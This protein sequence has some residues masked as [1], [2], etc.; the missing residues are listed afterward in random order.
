M[1]GAITMLPPLSPTQ[2]VSPSDGSRS[3]NP[4]CRIQWHRHKAS[5]PEASRTSVS[6]TRGT[7]RSSS[8]LGSAVSSSTPRDFQPSSHIGQLGSCPLMN[9]H[10][11][12]PGPTQGC[13]Y[14]AVGMQRALDS[15]IGL[16]SRST[17]ASWMLAF[18]MPADV[19]RSFKLPP[20]FVDCRRERLDATDPYETETGR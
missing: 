11:F 9:C 1:L 7:Q 8:M 16:P 6:L 10:A 19:R 20:E 18:L 4:D 14:I 17:S 12:S 15:V 3:A 13:P 5:P 2:T